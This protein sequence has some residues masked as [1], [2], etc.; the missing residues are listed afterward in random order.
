MKTIFIGLFMMVS[1]AVHAQTPTQVS[2]STRTPVKL[3]CLGDKP[4]YVVNNK[5][6][7]CDSVRFIKPDDITEIQVLRGT[8]ASALYGPTGSKNGTI[9]IT[10][11]NYAAPRKM[12][13]DKPEEITKP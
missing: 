11:K 1:V 13:T 10:T 6:L 5:I 12:K 8:S 3:D 2:A 7:P 9:I 4:L